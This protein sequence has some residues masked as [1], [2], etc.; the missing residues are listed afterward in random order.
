MFSLTVFFLLVLVAPMFLN[1]FPSFIFQSIS[2]SS[3]SP[4][5]LYLLSNRLPNNLK[6]SLEYWQTPI[7]SSIW[8]TQTRTRIKPNKLT[9]I[10]MEI[11]LA[12]QSKSTCGGFTHPAF[13]TKLSLWAASRGMFMKIILFC[14]ESPP[15]P[16]FTSQIP[17]SVTCTVTGTSETFKKEP[18]P[19]LHCK[20]S[21]ISF[22]CL[23]G[24]HQQILVWNSKMKFKS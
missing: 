14:V 11:N 22:V 21:F 24:S 19:H 20:R 18:F 16:R 5:F 2:L 17:Y 23:P 1:Y 10:I 3:I 6:P 13:H 15:S 4:C 8:S 9:L 12:A 7:L